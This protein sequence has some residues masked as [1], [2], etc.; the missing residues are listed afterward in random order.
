MP[1]ELFFQLNFGNPRK[2]LLLDNSNSFVNF[3]LKTLW[4]MNRGELGNV[5]PDSGRLSGIFI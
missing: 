1:S 5:R 4:D 3:I 2:M